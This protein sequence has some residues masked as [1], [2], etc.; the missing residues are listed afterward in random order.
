MN[1]NMLMQDKLVR[2]LFRLVGGGGFSIKAPST[3]PRELAVQNPFLGGGMTASLTNKTLAT[4]S[5]TAQSVLRSPMPLRVLREVDR[6]Q[7][8]RGI[9]RLVISG[10][11]ADVCAELDRL[12]ACEA[13]LH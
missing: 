3:K 4:E 5:A 11:M 6:S 2:G 12:A 1:I 10:R 9:G 8:Q 7:P 13:A